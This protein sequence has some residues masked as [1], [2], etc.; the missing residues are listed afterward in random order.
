MAELSSQAKRPDD[1]PPCLPGQEHE[2]EDGLLFLHP[3]TSHEEKMDPSSS[4][5]MSS[6]TKG[7]MFTQNW[8]TPQCMADRVRNNILIEAVLAC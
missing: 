3:L 8:A 4:T 5:V 7:W 6:E 2:G 1:E